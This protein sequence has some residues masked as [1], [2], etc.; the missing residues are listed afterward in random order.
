MKSRVTSTELLTAAASA[1]NHLGGSLREAVDP[2]MG[3]WQAYEC[4]RRA[5]A[6]RG[7]AQ[8]WII[9]EPVATRVQELQAA[10]AAAPSHDA[11]EWLDRFPHTVLEAIDRRSRVDS[12]PDAP[13]RRFGEIAREATV[14]RPR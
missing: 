3:T 12:L 5:L 10:L 9:P 2:D 7:R 11:L 4:G 14:A 6:A 13:R 8:E 1:Y